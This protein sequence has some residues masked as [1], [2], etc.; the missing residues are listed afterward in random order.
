MVEPALLGFPLEAMLWIRVQ[1]GRLETFTKHLLGD[2]CVRQ[3]MA[4]AGE[5]DVAVNVAV[6]D[7]ASLYAMVGGGPWREMVQSV[8]ISVVLQAM[9]RSGVR[10]PLGGLGT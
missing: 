10:M 5:F 4:I 3:A 1:P 2:P 9:K 6:R 8:Q 7:Q